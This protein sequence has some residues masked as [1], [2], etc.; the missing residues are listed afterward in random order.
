M[1]KFILELRTDFG[2]DE[3]RYEIIK[4]AMVDC[5]RQMKAVAMMI[6]ADRM[7]EIAV[8]TKDF[9]LGNEQIDV[10]ATP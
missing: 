3:E 8:H 4:T 1:R 6:S 5:A 2:D 7:P 9:I 10:N